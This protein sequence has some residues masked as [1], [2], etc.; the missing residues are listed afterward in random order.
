MTARFAKGLAGQGQRGTN[1][2]AG[3]PRQEWR[4]TGQHQEVMDYITRVALVCLVAA[5]T[6]A[7]HIRST[8][9]R[10][11]RGHSHGPRSYGVRGH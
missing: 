6:I 5:S 3:I 2:G 10:Q 1:I 9:D 11:T 4:T 8:A 7:A